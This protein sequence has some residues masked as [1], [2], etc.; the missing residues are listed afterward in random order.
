VL[1]A[2]SF[3]N[4]ATVEPGFRTRDVLMAHVFYRD[5]GMSMERRATFNRD[6]LARFRA[7][8]GVSEA[9]STSSPP[10]SGSFW[11]TEVKIDGKDVRETNVNQV[12]PGYFRVMG[13]P[14]V[15]GRDFDDR[16]SLGAP[17]VAIVSE[18]FA[19]T[20]LGG[21]PVLGRM[22]AIPNAPGTPD[23]SY[24]IVGLVGD[25]KYHNIKQAFPPILFIAE[26]QDE[27]PGGTRRFAIH[28][29]RAAS[30][31]M[32]DVVRVVAGADPNASLRFDVFNTLISRSLFRERLIAALSTG[33]GLLA[34]VLA[35]VGVFGVVSYGVSRRKG[36][37]GI[38]M[39]LGA[40]RTQ[41][42]G[43]ILGELMRVVAL[44]L[45]AGVAAA[46]LM[47]GY[48]ASLLFGLESNDALTLASAAI[49]LIL[50]GLA[51]ALVPA[52]H[53]ARLSPMIALRN[54]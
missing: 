49:V 12:T 42:V 28:S 48:V 52:Y 31:L 4:L 43:M 45:V 44:G 29:T 35:T 14:L 3:Q 10:L 19:R 53:A 17:R 15:A 47:S 36:E 37:I 1:F 7:I 27:D 30:D 32:A 20:L 50:T 40:R 9:A 51:A 24:Q 5:S 41:I 25:S 34:V 26:A 8:P 11:D 2:R 21:G 16:D 38:R 54:Q 46:L 13:T 6:L 39:A 33:F 18:T 22:V 23:T